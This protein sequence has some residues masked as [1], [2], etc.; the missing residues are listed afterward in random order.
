MR[1]KQIRN[2]YLTKLICTSLLAVMGGWSDPSW[3]QNIR[4]T[5]PNSAL[6][7]SPT[8]ISQDFSGSF[9]THVQ[10][11]RPGG[12]TESQRIT[13]IDLE[14]R[15]SNGSP[16]TDTGLRDLLDLRVGEDYSPV[17]I[18][19]ALRRIYQ[20]RRAS[21]AQ[22]FL[23]GGESPGS[24]VLRFVITR[25]ER[26]KDI[27][28]SG[29]Q[30]FSPEELRARLVGL[31]VNTPLSNRAV[32]EGQ[33]TLLGVFQEKG[34]FRAKI[35]WTI[36]DPD[37]D[38]RVDIT[39]RILQGDQALLAK[40]IQIEGN[41]KIDLKKLTE[42]LKGKP[43]IPYTTD[44]IQSDL[45]KIRQWHLDASYLSPQISLPF[46]EY[47]P[48]TN[49]VTVSANLDSGP[50]VDL[51]I[52][53]YDL[54]R[55]EQRDILPILRYGG[56]D[57]FVL[58]DGKRKMLTYLQTQ[59]YFFAA[60]D[61]TKSVFE[62]T[63]SVVY[64]VE[65][66]RRYRLEA[67]KLIG[68]DKFTILDIGPELLSQPAGILP[69]S[70]GK[71]SLESLTTDAGLIERKLRNLGYLQARVTERR[72]GISPDKPDF[73][74]TFVVDEGQRTLIK[75]V[76]FLGNDTFTA[77]RLRMEILA[78]APDDN[79]FSQERLNQDINQLYSLYEEAG[80]ARAVITPKIEFADAAPNEAKVTYQIEE[81]KRIFINDIFV[82]VRGR[83]HKH[84]V[85]QYLLFQKG[86][87]LQQS[88]LSQTEQNLYGTGLFNQVIT[89]IQPV[90]SDGPYRELYDVFI[91]VAEGK[92]YTLSYSVGIEQQE[93]QRQATPRFS[94]EIANRNLFGRLQTASLIFRLSQREQLGQVSYQFPRFLGSQ[95]PFLTTFLFQRSQEVSFSIERK[96]IQLRTERKLND[97]TSLIFR[98]QF[99]DVRPFDLEI[100]GDDLDRNN[101]PVKLGRISST[102]LRDS[103]DSALDATKGSFS[104]IDLSLASTKIG[105]TE[106][107]LRMFGQYQQFRALPKIPSVVFAS[108]VRIGLARPYGESINLP[109][110]ERFFS[111]GA[112]T[113]RGLDFE[114]AGPRDPIT[115]QPI[116]GNAV[117]VLNAELRYPIFRALTGAAFY[118]TGNVF[119]KVSNIR[120]GGFTNTVGTGIRLKTGL[121]PIRID[122]G[123]NLDPPSFVAVPNQ[124]LSRVQFHI[125]FG[126]AF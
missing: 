30:F 84:V 35:D 26:V 92:R 112:N 53:G 59:G 13:R 85:Q 31:D 60:V 61:Y 33:R 43:G 39:Y 95:W 64:T 99:D 98:Y 80:Y 4:S 15:F 91:D 71:T 65:K 2:N 27:F 115:D 118:D 36:S 105:G 44:L 50:L 75:E 100:S 123:Y 16:A 5:I 76:A 74:V 34:F 72:L 25:Q 109:I 46:A 102:Y 9:P 28:F 78:H 70:R 45:E 106:R 38:G 108:S 125:S 14:V 101:R 93:V 17:K 73:E 51:K 21:N 120:L 113:I 63:A 10:L 69:R 47:D 77:D 117:V 124:K 103:R 104:I 114:Q 52:E 29:N 20:S 107:Y 116:G 40:P 1:Q 87:L 3:G 89:R 24:V 7:S 110:S 88:K 42:K 62:E 81:G 48:A 11:A 126:Q 86:N 96:S 121:G 23:T 90:R 82:T 32:E 119:D 41:I 79:Y 67:V 18:N 122:M 37:V 8:E 94:F 68:T 55:K 56:L 58:E 6:Q 54:S 83:T 12:G 49:T 19:Q 22:V 111:G 57:D 97:L 66:D